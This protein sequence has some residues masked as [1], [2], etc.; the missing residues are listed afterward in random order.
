MTIVLPHGVLFRG[1]DEE[2]IRKNLIEQNHIDAIIGLPANIFFGT[3]IPTIVMVLKQKRDN[4]DVLIVDA[5]KGFIK[6]GKNNKL[7]SSDIKKIVDTVI[8][9]KTI[10]KFSRKVERDEI[11]QNE[12][13]LNIPRYV[14]SS[15]KAE[16]WDIYSSMF[17]GIPNKEIEE[18]KDLWT[19]FPSLKSS[20]FKATN[21]SFSDFCVEDIKK[22]ILESSDVINYFA[23]YNNSFNDFG[24]FLSNQLID[25]LNDVN[26]SREETII[27]DDIFRRVAA[28]PLVDK[29][30]AFQLLDDE[31]NKVATDIEI[32]QTEGF[33]CTK[34]VDPHYVIKK[35]DGKDVEVQ[36]GWEGHIIPFDLIWKTM[37]KEEKQKI[38]AKES[39]L[40]EIS[41]SFSEILE[42]ISDDDKESNSNLFNDENDAFV[43][44]QVTKMAKSLKGK[45]AEDSLENKVLMVSKLIE[46][47]KQLKK[48]VKVCL[49]ELEVDTKKAIENLSNEQVIELLKAK[50]INPVV[51]NITK[52]PSILINEY[53]SKLIKLSKKYTITLIK[54]DE[55][56]KN[57]ESSLAEMIDELD[58][59]EFDLKGLNEFKKLLGGK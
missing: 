42:S 15:E 57:S 35:K 32:I 1:G 27:A 31:W 46:E 52:L 7:Q 38:D 13:N 51:E 3:G 9:R 49:S 22:Q 54:L 29:Y 12:Y 36:E 19:A 21:A 55:E 6:V 26:V 50:W 16:S 44:A 48:D 30:K 2:K 11:R 23:T 34:I 59:N 24:S 40:S 10:D 8:A 53:L 41:S 25:N 17:G 58:A 20:L 37:L 4:T 14:D 28:I 47:E 56:I 39:R 33:D 43:N 5:S 18:F 45:Y